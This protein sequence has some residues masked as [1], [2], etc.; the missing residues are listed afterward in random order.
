M[1]TKHRIDYFEFERLKDVVEDGGKINIKLKSMKAK[2]K[3]L[4][5]DYEFIIQYKNKSGKM[6]IN[7]KIIADYSEPKKV[8]ENWKKTRRIPDDLSAELINEIANYNRIRAA[9]VIRALHAKIEPVKENQ[10]KTNMP[11]A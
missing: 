2:E 8:V 5:I 10:E 11:A 6:Q 9:A 7:G 4:E 3:E 1:I